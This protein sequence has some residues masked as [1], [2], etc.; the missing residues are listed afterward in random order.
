LGAETALKKTFYP[1]LMKPILILLLALTLPQF[2]PCQEPPIQPR[3]TITLPIRFHLVQ[4][5]TLA[6][7][8]T[9]LIDSDIQRILG[10]I[11]Q[12]WAQAGIQFQMESITP[13]SAIPMDPKMRLK[14]EFDRVHSMI[15]KQS[16]CDHAID[17]CYVKQ[18]GPNGFYYGE[19]IV[20]KDT[21]K[22][23]EVAGGLD[24]PLPRVTSHELGHALGLKHRQNNTNLM[25]SGTTGFSLNETEITTARIKAQE[26]LT[27]HS[28]KEATVQD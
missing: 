16:L 24:E 1:I 9:T 25:Q 7:M 3:R 22:L 20:V 4:S 21:A 2:S 6:D 15:P 19:P 18:V 11:N 26:F 27:K 12:V 23:R 28:P 10:K 5:K 13:T 8:H 17:I 14:P